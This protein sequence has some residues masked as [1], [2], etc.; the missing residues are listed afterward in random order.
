MI[1]VVMTPVSDAKVC[2]YIDFAGVLLPAILAESPLTN[3]LSLY[4]RIIS[5][6]ENE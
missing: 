5:V 2:S 4:F 3:E 1:Q 6:N